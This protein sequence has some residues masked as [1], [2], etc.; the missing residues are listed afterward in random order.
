MTDSVGHLLLDEHAILAPTCPF[1]C[2]SAELVDLARAVFGIGATYHQRAL[3]APIM[4]CRALPRPFVFSQTL[5]RCCAE[6]GNVARSRVAKE[7]HR[8]A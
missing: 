5:V 3:G 8:A 6:P 2:D 7:R 1:T 4:D